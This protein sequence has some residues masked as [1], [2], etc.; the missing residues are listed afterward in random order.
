MKQ[1]GFLDFD[2]RLQRSDKAGDPLSKL[3]STV[4]WEIF[5]P[6]LEQAFRLWGKS[7]NTNF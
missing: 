5:R 7:I 3:N 1:L 2:T 6:F 4:D